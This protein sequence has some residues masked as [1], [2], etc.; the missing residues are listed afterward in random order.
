M[1]RLSAITAYV[2]YVLYFTLQLWMSNLSFVSLSVCF[3]SWRGRTS[4][5]LPA[6]R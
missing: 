2:Q 1:Y 5:L 6:K 4:S 3:M